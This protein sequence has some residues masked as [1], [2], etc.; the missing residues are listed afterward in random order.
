MRSQGS[1]LAPS[2]LSLTHSWKIHSTRTIQAKEV[3]HGG[4]AHRAFE[5]MPVISWSSDFQFHPSGCTL[6]ISWHRLDRLF[7]TII[8][9]I[10]VMCPSIANPIGRIVG[11]VD[12]CDHL[13]KGK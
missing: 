6:R 1:L 7:H 13:T 2:P 9:S 3:L 8:D 10:V 5:G 11:G 4:T 12:R